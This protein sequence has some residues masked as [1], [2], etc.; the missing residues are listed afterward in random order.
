MP[1]SHGAGVSH[2]PAVLAGAAAGGGEVGPPD[3]GGELTGDL[4]E[5]SEGAGD[6]AQRDTFERFAEVGD[7]LVELGP[8]LGWAAAGAGAGPEFVGELHVARVGVGAVRESEQVGVAQRGGLLL[9]SVGDG[10]QA[11][12]ESKIG[13][14]LLAGLQGPAP[15]LIGEL[16]LFDGDAGIVAH[17]DGRGAG[18]MVMM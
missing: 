15:T 2:G 12:R 13:R 3:L 14:R 8:E 17:E 11:L 16:D 4:G 5:F 18:V 9:G 1:H 6:R 7:R 10:A